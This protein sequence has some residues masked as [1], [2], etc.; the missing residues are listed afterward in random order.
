MTHKWWLIGDYFQ[1]STLLQSLNWKNLPEN[2]DDKGL[3]HSVPCICLCRCMDLC[4]VIDVVRFQWYDIWKELFEDN[5]W[6]TWLYTIHND[7]C[8]C[9]VCTLWIIM[10][11]LNNPI[12]IEISKHTHIYIYIHRY[13]SCVL[14]YVYIYC[15]YKYVYIYI[16]KS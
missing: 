15:M 4:I 3:E 14:Q 2:R 8:T 13:N 6:G 16:Y 11:Y 10:I 1:S 7:Y 5:Q 9:N 12:N